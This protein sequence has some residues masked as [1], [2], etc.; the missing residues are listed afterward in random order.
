MCPV[1]GV[2]PGVSPPCAEHAGP[3]GTNGYDALRSG[4]TAD[5]WPRYF[6][7]EVVASTDVL[8]NAR[9]TLPGEGVA[10][11]GGN[12]HRFCGLRIFHRRAKSSLGGLQECHRCTPCLME[13]RQM[14]RAEG[15]V[16]RGFYSIS[17]G[18]ASL[19][20]IIRQLA[21]SKSPFYFFP[22]L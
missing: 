5:M 21:S 4:L 1:A 13:D 20:E 12:T 14:R 9:H 7:Q 19:C 6:A 18:P 17:G 22:R 2:L 8:A 10:F 16:E 11:G 3:P 15:G